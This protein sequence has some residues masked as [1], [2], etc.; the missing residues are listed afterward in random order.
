MFSR[1]VSPRGEATLH[2]PSRDWPKHEMSDQAVGAKQF[3]MASFGLTQPYKCH[4]RLGERPLSYQTRMLFLK[5]ALGAGLFL[6]GN[7][8]DCH[9]RCGRRIDTSYYLGLVCENYV[10]E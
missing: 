3:T 2:S 10:V 4:A 5:K 8:Q 1:S 6:S 7:M 9:A